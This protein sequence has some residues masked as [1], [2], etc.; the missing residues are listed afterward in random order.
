MKNAVATPHVVRFG[1]FEVDLRTEELRKGGM[2]L[3]L[4]GQPFQVLAILLEHPGEVVTREELQQRLWPDTFVDA[5][6][7]LNTAINKIREVLGDSAESPRFVETLPRKGYRFVGQ[8]NA[9]P[10]SPGENARPVLKPTADPTRNW[11]LRAAGGVAILIILLAGSVPF[12]GRRQPLKPLEAVPLTALS[13]QEISPSF[14]PDGSQVAFGWDGENNG[15]GFDLYVKV[16]GTEKPL[17]LTNHPVSWLSTAWSP[18]GRHIAVHRLAPDGGG[19]FLVPALGG[20]EEKIASTRTLWPPA[21]PISWSPDGKQLAFVD[22]PEVSGDS[23]SLF[24][25]SL[26]TF[27]RTPAVTGCP[28]VYTAAFSPDGASLVF[29]CE[30]DYGRYSL[31]LLSL[32]KGTNQVLFRGP[33]GI[34][35]VGWSGDGKRVVF[36]RDYSLTRGGT[37]ELWQIATE[38]GSQ[39]EKIPLGH[40]VDLLALSAAGNRLAY[41]QSWRSTNIWRIDLQTAQPRAEGLVTSTREQFS[42]S[43]SPDGRQIVFTSTRSGALEIWVCDSD[44]ANVRQ[45]TFFGGALTGTPRWSPDSKQIAFD[46]RA[47]G[48]ANVYLID[49]GGG[50]PRK[51]ET[52]TRTNSMP[53]WSHNGRWIY[54]V[55]G[56][57][58]T[59]WRSPAAGGRAEQL[60]HTPGAN[61][62]TESADGLYVYFVRHI[63]GTPW[64]WRINSDGS[65]ERPV[66]GMPA[67]HS[68]FGWWPY[69]SG[70][71][72]IA[73]V[74]ANQEIDFLDLQTSK[75]RRIY[76][77]EKPA[78]PSLGGL[79]VSPDGKWL[80]YSQ[81]DEIVSDLMLVE[82]FH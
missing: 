61:M 60:T 23:Q 3:K 45:L 47:D 51:L 31:K 41:A 77:P 50:I 36:S 9:T 25:L 8:V 29:V 40:D 55:S 79:A 56:D 81:I 82:N 1:I 76:R 48:E 64:L 66:P 35:G 53:S 26:S 27:E 43:F 59:V 42:P 63:S 38:P 6:R 2:K 54:F 11:M 67:M 34:V 5:E 22:P 73:G 52:G 57:S 20:P 30:E 75:V 19:I 78:L 72:F 46:S 65:D 71:Y 80:L 10:A 74:G 14:S 39:P 12:A 15:A 44:G 49:A 4:S 21:A 7:G 62:P 69:Q 37:G 58:A 18:D 17:R 13:G 32:Q 33:T 16:V 24:L 70:I 68:T 28:R